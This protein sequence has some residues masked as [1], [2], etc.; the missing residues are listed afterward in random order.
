MG[1]PMNVFARLLI[2]ALVVVGGVWAWRELRPARNEAIAPA[3]EVSAGTV[4]SALVGD[5]SSG[6]WTSRDGRTIKATFLTATDS[7]VT[8]RRDDGQVFTIPFANLSPNDVA[9][10]TRQARR[11]GITQQQL[12]EIVARFPHPPGVGMEVTNDL[13]Q[14]HEKYRG[15]VKFLRPNTLD[16]SLKMIR[17]RMADDVKTLSHV[18]G[19]RT[20]DWTGKRGSGQSAAAESAILSAR[21]SLGWLEGELSEHI[22]AYEALLARG[23]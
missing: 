3:R 16:A 14:L 15:M 7:A 17:S 5:P 1:L 21:S 9:W 4:A 11:P 23:E 10:V 20:G 12:D 18:A 6:V 8:V 13:R 22:R 19:T 2:F